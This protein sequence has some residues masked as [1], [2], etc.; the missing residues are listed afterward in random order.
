MEVFLQWMDELDDLFGSLALG[1]LR[2]RDLC[3]GLAT[4][5]AVGLTLSACIYL[6]L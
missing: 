3:L 1:W 6:I 4:V 2:I 5:L